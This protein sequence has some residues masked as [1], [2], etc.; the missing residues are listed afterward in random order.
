MVKPNRLSLLLF[1]S[2]SL[3]SFGVLVVQRVPDRVAVG[4][5]EFTYAVRFAPA[6]L[7][8][9]DAATATPVLKL[10]VLDWSASPTP[11][12]V[13]RRDAKSDWT[14]LDTFAETTSVSYRLCADDTADQWRATQ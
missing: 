9:T 14:T 8:D 10:V 5:P 6:A 7:G 12:A 1:G 4:S 13:Q 11:V 2:A 3:L